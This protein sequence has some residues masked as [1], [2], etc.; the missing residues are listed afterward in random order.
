MWA[1]LCDLCAGGEALRA[2]QAGQEGVERIRTLRGLSELRAHVCTFAPLGTRRVEQGPPSGPWV[3]ALGLNFH[4]DLGRGRRTTLV[5]HPGIFQ[6]FGVLVRPDTA[7]MLGVERRLRTLV[8]GEG[9]GSRGKGKGKGD[10]TMTE[11]Q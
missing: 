6:L 9:L 10:A 3:W 2:S 11:G 5:E 7:P 4:T 1:T 8:L